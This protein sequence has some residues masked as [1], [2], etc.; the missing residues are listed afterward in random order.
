MATPRITDYK[1]GRIRVD[2][3]SYGRDVI[4]SPDAVFAGWWRTKGHSLAMEDLAV[5]LEAKPEVLVIGQGTFAQMQVPDETLAGLEA[6]GIETIAQ[7]TREAC[8]TYNRLR[9]KRRVV[10]ALHLAC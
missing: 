2:G 10:A 9:Q 5:A 8:R 7:P 6:A 3:Q 4:I 1:F